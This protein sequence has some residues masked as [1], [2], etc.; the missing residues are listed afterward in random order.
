MYSLDANVLV[1]AFDSGAGSRHGRALTILARSRLAE[2][3]L[4]LQVIGEF[5]V[6]SRRS[7]P[8]DTAVLAA[9]AGDLSGTFPC[10]APSAGAVRSALREAAA[11][12]LQYWDALLLATLREAG[13]N[14]L[15]S[16]DL[17]HGVEY[18]GVRVLNPFLGE[19]LPAEIE[20]LLA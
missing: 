20:A 15:L 4:T 5:F 3:H 10:L 19:T 13:C 14:V 16:E 11:R 7:R 18:D 6:A 2:C 17:Q 9:H 8:E 12:R 1:Y